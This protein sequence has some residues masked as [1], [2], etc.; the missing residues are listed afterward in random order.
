M[1]NSLV[2]WCPMSRV[3]GQYTRQLFYCAIWVQ[4]GF[5]WYYLGTTEPYVDA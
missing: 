2:S 4:T 3:Y 1:C 5:C